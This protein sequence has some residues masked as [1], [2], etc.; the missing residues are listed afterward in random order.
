MHKTWRFAAAA[1]FVLAIVAGAFVG[2]QLLALSDHTRDR[3]RL[4]TELLE[5]S[6]EAYGS[7]VTYEDLVFAS[8]RGM[9]RELDPHTNFLSPDAYTSMR[10]RQQGSFYGLGIL[11]GVRDGKL[12]VITPIPGSPADRLGMKAGD[13]ISL[14]EGDPTETMTLDDA[15]GRLKGPKDTKVTITVVRRGL[16]DPLELT[17]TRAEVTQE[18]VSY[19]YM[20]DDETGYVAIRDFARS[21]GREVAE[22]LKRLKG[23]GMKRLVLD[24]R[25]NGGGLLD[26]AI[27]VADQFVPGES[28]IV[29]TRGRI[30]SSYST[31]SSSG[32][33]EELGLPLVVLVNGGTAS[34]AEILS[35][36]IQDHDVGLVIGEQTWGKGLV[37][38]VYTLPYGAGIALTTAKYYTPSGRLIQRDY[39]SYWDYY[40]D[41]G[42][43]DE[44]EVEG[45]AENPEAQKK[46]GEVFSTDLGRKVYGGGGIT[47]DVESTLDSAPDFVQFLRARAAF[48]NFAVDYLRESPVNTKS[49]QP[50]D[51]VFEKLRS[52]LKQESIGTPQEIDEAFA[53][54]ETRKSALSEVQIEV[55]T[56]AF[57][58]TEGHRVR[59]RIDNQLQKALSLFD[60]AR[61]LLETREAIKAT[62]KSP[63]VATSGSGPAG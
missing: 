53:E 9:L 33:Y 56:A 28:K 37:Q 39:S 17:I 41:Y 42:H 3:L 22:A 6:K 16:E 23:E 12:T 59:S 50:D 49:W 43:D 13:V 29:E 63:Q 48:L 5:T 40:A 62:K 35:G 57:G 19:E 4:Y 18:T 8:I 30:R 44:V 7:D 61:E 10:D 11:V 58:V 36:A 21:T 51:V 26:Q 2:D 46:L 54:A 47:P 55:M 25:N 32:K 20:L 31:Y 45:D 14:I 27:E 34:A 1:L 38:T 52:W 60:D 24:L 15:V